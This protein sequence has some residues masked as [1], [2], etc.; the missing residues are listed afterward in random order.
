MERATLNPASSLSLR[1]T[2]VQVYLNPASIYSYL[3]VLDKG[4]ERK[5]QKV[6]DVIHYAA[7]S[8]LSTV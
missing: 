6:L 4:A 8:V 5:F 3:R 7:Y 1:S 2:S